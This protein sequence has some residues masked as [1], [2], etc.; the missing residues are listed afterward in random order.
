MQNSLGGQKSPDQFPCAGFYQNSRQMIAHILRKSHLNNPTVPFG[1]VPLFQRVLFGPLGP[2]G[3]EH[4]RTHEDALRR[5]SAFWAT[6]SSLQCLDVEPPRR[7]AALDCQCRG[8]AR[9]MPYRHGGRHGASRLKR[10]LFAGDAPAGQHQAVDLLRNQRTIRNVESLVL[11]EEP[12]AVV[13]GHGVGTDGDHVGESGAAEGVLL[14]EHIFPQDAARFPH[15]N[16]RGRLRQVQRL[17]AGPLTQGLHLLPELQPRLDL[18]PGQGFYVQAVA[19]EAGSPA[20]HAVAQADPPW[21]SL[22]VDGRPPS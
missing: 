13:A 10:G 11:E 7:D 16:A 18:G 5:S 15:P 8:A 22:G 9:G 2:V 19:G 6:S 3:T 1:T 12:A 20:D 14:A 4:G 21:A 17:A